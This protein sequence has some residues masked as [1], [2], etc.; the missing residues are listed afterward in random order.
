DDPERRACQTLTAQGR[1]S[2]SYP[3]GSAAVGTAYAELLALID[4]E[5]AQ[6]LRTIGH[7]IGL[8]RLVCA[9]HY[10]SDVAAGE[11]IG[12]ATASEFGRDPQFLQDIEAARRE[13]QAARATGKTNPGCAAERA[14][15]AAPLP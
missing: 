6:A 1:E 4:P 2:A 12:R 13:L 9:M 3:S 15:L 14:A 8:S 5:R 10:P 7:E 11:E